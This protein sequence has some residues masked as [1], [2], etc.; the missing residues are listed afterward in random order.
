MDNIE[1]LIEAA[2][3]T[4]RLEERRRIVELLISEDVLHP[5]DEHDQGIMELIFA[6]EG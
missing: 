6:G 4:V 2:R 1:E 3:E 5:D